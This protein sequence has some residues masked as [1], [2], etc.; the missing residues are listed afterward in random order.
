MVYSFLVETCASERLKPLSVGRR[1]RDE[2][3]AAPPHPRLDRDRTAH[4][5]MVHQCQSEDRWF[6]T[7]F[8]IDLGSP[9]LPETETRLA[10]IQRYADDSGRRLA[11]LREKN[12]AWWAEDVAFFD[13]IHSRAWIMVRRVA[14]TP[15]HPGGPTTPLP[16]VGRQ[17]PHAYPPSIDTAGPA[18]HPAVTIHTS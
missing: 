5:H 2:D 10:F 11:R 9:P 17:G 12:E 3:P 18:H 15:P 8:D 6:R 14:H 1:L 13:T 16:L 7:M 4:E